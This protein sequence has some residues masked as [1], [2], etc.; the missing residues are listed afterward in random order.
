MCQHYT[1]DT[2]SFL[3]TNLHE[4]D[5]PI[6]NPQGSMNAS[7]V[8]SDHRWSREALNTQGRV[9]ITEYKNKRYR[10]SQDK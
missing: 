5:Q 7:I 10:K 9:E 6:V 8:S 3:T 1:Y 2:Q 4:T